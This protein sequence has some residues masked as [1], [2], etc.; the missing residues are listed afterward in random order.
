MSTERRRS[1]SSPSHVAK[2]LDTPEELA[3]RSGAEG[4]DFEAGLHSGPGLR[5]FFQIME[6]WAAAPDTAMAMLGVPRAT[7][8]KW[9]RNPDSARLSRDQ[10][11]RVSYVLG[12]YKALQILLPSP[13]NANSWVSRPNDSSVFGGRPPIEIMSQGQVAD[14]YR[15]RQFLDAERGW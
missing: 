1:A 2:P 11:E 3:P 9:K 6:A 4:F 12:I 7:Y 5:T 15:V 8:Y 10:L 14:L 13:G